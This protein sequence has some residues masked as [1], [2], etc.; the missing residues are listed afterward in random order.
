MVRAAGFEE[1][2]LSWLRVDQEF[3]D[4]HK[5]R[6]GV[7]SMLQEHGLLVGE[8]R[9]I[10]LAAVGEDQLA[11]TVGAVQEQMTL[12]KEI[13]IS[14]I[15]LRA[16]DRRRQDMGLLDKIIRSALAQAERLDMQVHLV[17]AYRSRIEQVLDWQY[18]IESL[19]SD[20]LRVAL[21]LGELHRSGGNVQETIVALMPKLAMV[22]VCDR[23][24]AHR[25]SIGKGEINL[26]AALECLCQERYAGPFVVEPCAE[27]DD[28][29]ATLTSTRIYL[30][31]ALMLLR[32]GRI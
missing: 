1:V 28:L 11:E 26:P 25:V 12:A 29:E 13:G 21:D 23:V 18:L 3:Q 31:H 14:S 6:D 30:A 20:C 9:G 7:V 24:G 4:E 15:T 16:G 32:Q 17:N 8:F 19:G 2:E 5:R 10:D 22:R 27:T